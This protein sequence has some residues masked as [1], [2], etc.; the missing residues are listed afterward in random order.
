MMEICQRFMGLFSCWGKEKDA[1]TESHVEELQ[2]E[3]EKAAVD[4][5]EY[6][7][8]E[9]KAA[10]ERDSLVKKV[11]ELESVIACEEKKRREDIRNWEDKVIM[12][13][14]ECNIYQTLLEEQGRT[15][16]E[17]RSMFNAE[18]NE[19]QKL[20]LRFK[21]SLFREQIRSKQVQAPSSS[22]KK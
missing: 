14:F 6:R 19:L 2:A 10:D 11:T 1:E 4:V 15:V 7:M 20:F 9:K 17:E 5:E 18:R 3:L 22:R 12:K 8:R 21:A 13:T 16:E